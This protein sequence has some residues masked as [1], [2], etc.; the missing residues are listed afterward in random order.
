M[1]NFNAI[2]QWRVQADGEKPINQYWGERTAIDP[3]GTLPNGVEFGNFLE[4]KRAL[5]AQKNR[6]ARGLTEKLL[7]YALGRTIEP[8]DRP[9]IDRMLVAADKDGMTIKSLVK[10]IVNSQPFQTK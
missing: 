7:M 10:Q 2:G 5:L 3:S 4:F 9:I 8:T 1:E 6:F